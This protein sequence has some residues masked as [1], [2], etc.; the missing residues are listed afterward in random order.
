MQA[1]E[2]A[3]RPLSSVNVGVSKAVERSFGGNATEYT[4]DRPG[5]VGRSCTIYNGI[6]VEAFRASVEEADTA[7]LRETYGLTGDEL[8]FLNVGRY[9]PQKAQLDLVRAMDDVVEERP[10]ARL[11][12]VGWGQMEDELDRAVRERELDEHVFI[13]GRVPTVEEYYA[14]ADVFVLSSLREGL[15]IV[16]LEAMAAGLPVVSTNVSGVPE[17]VRD[18]ET[19]RLVG[20]ESPADLATAMLEYRRSGRRERTGGRGYRH[21]LERFDVDR[22]AD[23]YSSLYRSLFGQSR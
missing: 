16:L 19:G 20:P 1:L 14:I 5:A 18:G 2:R 6:D 21:A 9:T 3:T 15:P 13:T 4:A 23:Q 10:D 17:A 7:P 22:T 8:V 11:F 12:V